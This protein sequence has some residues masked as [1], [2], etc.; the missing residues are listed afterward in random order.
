MLAQNTV[1]RDKD[2]EEWRA[3][4]GSIALGGVGTAL[5]DEPGAPSDPGTHAP[6][7]RCDDD[8]KRTEKG[9]EGEEEGDEDGLDAEEAEEDDDEEGFEGDDEFEDD[10]DE[11]FDGEDDDDEFGE[12]LDDEDDEDDD[13]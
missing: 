1:L 3:L 10:D 13:F 11:F 2:F 6:D 12:D 5:G 7:P 9:G 8:A 4:E